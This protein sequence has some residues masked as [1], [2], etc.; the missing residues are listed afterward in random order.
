L[1]TSRS[2]LSSRWP[3][4]PSGFPSSAPAQ[5]RDSVGTALL[6]FNSSLRSLL[7]STPDLSVLGTSLGVSF[8]SA[9]ALRR[10][11][12]LRVSPVRLPDSGIRGARAQDCLA[13]NLPALPTVAGYGPAHRF[14]QP[15]SEFFLS[16]PSRHFQ[17]GNAL[18]IHPFRGFVLLRVAA[19]HR[20]GHAL[21]TFSPASCAV[22]VLGRDTRR[23]TDA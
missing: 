8:P 17:T 18:G 4:D 21:V 5:G 20:L 19:A 11:H 3:P 9:Y 14:S 7:H 10:V 15:Q 12:V 23:R 22:P 2:G 1:L 6:R 13:R 16:L